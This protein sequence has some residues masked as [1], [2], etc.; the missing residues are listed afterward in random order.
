M[1]IDPRQPRGVEQPFLLVELPAARLLRHQPP[2]QPVGE[3]GDRALQMDEL[4]VEI[5]AQPAQLLLVA[6]LGRPRPSSSIL[7]GEDRD[8]RSSAAGRTAAGSG[9]PA[10]SPPRPPRRARRDASPI[11]SSDQSLSPSS[12]PAPALLAA[13]LGL[14]AAA[15]LV[16]VVAS[17]SSPPSASSSPSPSS[18][19]SGSASGLG[20]ALDQLEVAQQLGG[21][22]GEGGLVVEREAERVEIGAGLLLDPVGDQLEPGARRLGR[23]LAGQPLAHHQPDRGGQRHLLAAARPGQRIG[24]A[25][26]SRS[27]RARLARTPA[28]AARAE[29]LDPRLLGGVEHRAGDLVGRARRGACSAAL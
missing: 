18:P 19:S 16:L 24:P 11:S 3:L 27:S 20:L 1:T 12:S 22:R 4:L 2:L 7:G 29:R 5:G 17:S 14:A 15:A 23:R 28:I 6:Q 8:S 10:A 13:D 21:Q 26:A 9:G 25:A